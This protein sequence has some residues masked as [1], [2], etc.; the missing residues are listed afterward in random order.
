MPRSTAR[1]TTR[2]ISLRSPSISSHAAGHGYS[3]LAGHVERKRERRVAETTGRPARH[4]SGNGCAGRKGGGRHR[5][6]QQQVVSSKEVLYVVPQRVALHHGGCI[7][8]G[9]QRLS[10]ADELDQATVHLVAPLRQEWPKR[11]GKP[12]RPENLERL[13]RVAKMGGGL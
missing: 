5:G 9:R 11:R 1:A 2:T 13:Y 3:R 4:H 6:R 12:T 8:G 10:R 7:G